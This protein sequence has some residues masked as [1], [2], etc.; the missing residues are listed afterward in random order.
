MTMPSGSSKK[1]E[2]VSAWFIDD[3][4]LVTEQHII[5]DENLSKNR[6]VVQASRL[7]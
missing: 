5:I 6:T 2:E 7:T 3:A 4:L 1:G